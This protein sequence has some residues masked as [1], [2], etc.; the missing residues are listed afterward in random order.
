VED[1]ATQVRG[2]GFLT[3]YYLH[4]DL[5]DVAGQY[6]TRLLDVVT[7]TSPVVFPTLDGYVACAA[8]YLRALS[9]NPSRDARAQAFAACWALAGY[10]RAFEIGRP[11]A[12]AFAGWRAM[13]QDAPGKALRLAERARG[14]AER[15]NLPLAEAAALAL[16]LRLSRRDAL[17]AR[18][19]SLRATTDIRIDLLLPF[20][21]NTGD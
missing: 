19:E 1:V 15:L 18:A 20:S 5:P 21:S 11:Y 17:A 7:T 9:L 14:L 13:L 12:L 4:F 10:G 3:L 2:W 8:F 6:A 16:L